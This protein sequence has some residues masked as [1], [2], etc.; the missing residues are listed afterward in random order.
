MLESR[1][2]IGRMTRTVVGRSVEPDELTV[3]LNESAVQVVGL[4]H[5]DELM[6]REATRVVAAVARFECGDV[7]VPLGMYRIFSALPSKVSVE[8]L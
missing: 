2:R 8:I 1:K 7:T 6:V 4:Q 3:Y 5:V